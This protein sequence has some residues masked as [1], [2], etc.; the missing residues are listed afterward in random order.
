MSELQVEKESTAR[1]NLPAKQVEI[2]LHGSPK[3]LTDAWFLQAM[4]F[5]YGRFGN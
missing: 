5:K 2:L 3:C 1:S 4:K